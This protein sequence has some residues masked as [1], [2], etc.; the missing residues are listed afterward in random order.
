MTAPHSRYPE[1]RQ[2]F[3]SGPTAGAA[4]HSAIRASH[5]CKFCYPAD[6]A[7]LAGSRSCI[8][9]KQAAQSGIIW[10][11][12]TKYGQ[13]TTPVSIS[14]IKHTNVLNLLQDEAN[15]FRYGNITLLSLTSY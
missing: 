2:G 8:R 15:P 13:D 11:H 10:R 9:R 3:A 4:K 14:V 6:D 1:E 5:F 7:M 12:Y